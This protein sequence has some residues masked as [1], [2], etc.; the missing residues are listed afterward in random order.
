[1]LQYRLMKETY[2]SFQTP[3]TTVQSFQKALGQPTRPVKRQ[4]A[5]DQAALLVLDLQSFFL[6]PTSHAFIPSVGAILPSL[7]AL[8]KRFY[9]RRRPV[10]FTQHMNTPE[11][12][13]M[14]A[15][16]WRDLILPDSPFAALDA[17]LDTSQA[18]IIHKS[19]YDAFFQTELEASLRDLSIKQV[20]I[21]GVMTH[22]C[23]ETTARSAFTRGFQVF[24]PIDGTA[25]Y[26]RDFHLAALRNLAHGFATLC[27]V[28]DLI[29]AMDAYAER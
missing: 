5:P 11:N 29:E 15:I 23:C 2:F 4:F 17:R 3:D 10:F 19:Q 22:L 16:W 26:N 27:T 9:A 28:P 1:M 24:F 7:Q 20:V 8:L 25:T 21:V 12:A 6:D 14:M 13:G 18:T